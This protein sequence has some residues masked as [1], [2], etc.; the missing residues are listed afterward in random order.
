MFFFVLTDRAC[1]PIK[2]KEGDCLPI[3][4]GDV[5]RVINTCH[6]KGD[7]KYWKVCLYDRQ[8]GAWGKEGLIS[9]E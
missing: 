2:E 3:K 9:S 8:K 4:K 1:A 6:L 5:L 7:H